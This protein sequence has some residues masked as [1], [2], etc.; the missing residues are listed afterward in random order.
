MSSTPD[1]RAVRRLAVVVARYSAAPGTPPGIDPA[2]F[3]RSCLAD[4][5]EVLAGL[6]EVDAGI[7]G[8]ADVAE[9][10]WP[11]DRRWPARLG[12]LD[13]ASA[14]A[15][16]ADE[17]VFV[18]GDVPDLPELV[19]AKVFK[20]LRHADVAIAPERRG[21]GCAAIGVRLPVADWLRGSDLD[22]DLNPAMALAPIAPHRT[23]CA[24]TPDWHR[25]RRPEAV[26]R[27]DPALEGWEETRALLSG[28]PLGLAD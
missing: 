15:D 16:E 26:H 11:G 21:D 5:Y 8:P 17:V 3:A 2:A 28:A 4:T 27:L 20:A 13:L 9:L 25:M 14:L 1:P 12:L 7:V 10:L 23:S 22:L 19:V 24:V 6:T 18:P